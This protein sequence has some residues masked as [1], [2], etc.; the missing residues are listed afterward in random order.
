MRLFC[1]I[2]NNKKNKTNLINLNLKICFLA[3]Y[4]SRYSSQFMK[5]VEYVTYCNYIV[6]L[7]LAP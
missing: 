1:D 3:I 7:R 2:N 4:K 6:T 5:N